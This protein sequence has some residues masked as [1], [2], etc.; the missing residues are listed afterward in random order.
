MQGQATQAATAAWSEATAMSYCH[1]PGSDMRQAAA[2]HAQQSAGCTASGCACT[3][4]AVARAL[5][6][7]Y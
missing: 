1:D 7:A 3:A 6:G 2:A 5:H 4:L